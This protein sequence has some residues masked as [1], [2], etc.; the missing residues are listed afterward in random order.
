MEKIPGRLLLSIWPDISP[1]E[2]DC[3]IAALRENFNELRQLVPPNYYG[4]LGKRYFLDGIFWTQ[5]P[6]PAINGPFSSGNA[7][8][9]AMAQKYTYDGR[10]SYRADDYRQC[11]PRVLHDNGPVFTHGEFQRKNI[12]V[13][14]TGEQNSGDSPKFQIVI[15]DWEKS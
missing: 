8:I 10:S 15:L 1:A 11:L 9:E 2:K 7:I 12:I 13:Q 6:E 14:K 4:S 5:S 3:I